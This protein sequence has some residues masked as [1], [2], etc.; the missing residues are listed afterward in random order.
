MTGA[1]KLTKLLP[2]ETECFSWQNKV[3]YWEK[4]TVLSDKMVKAIER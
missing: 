1:T 2:K 4:Q 3:F